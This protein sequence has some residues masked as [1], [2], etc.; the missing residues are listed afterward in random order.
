MCAAAPLL[1]LAEAAEAVLD[2]LLPLGNEKPVFVALALLVVE[3]EEEVE[4][5]ATSK[6]VV[7]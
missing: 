5:G 3:A 2:A 4:V 6:V 1:A 7:P